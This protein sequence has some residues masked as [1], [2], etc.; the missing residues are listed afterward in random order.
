MAGWDR[1]M[2]PAPGA[3]GQNG[4]R[5]QAKRAIAD[6]VTARP[7]AVTAIPDASGTQAS[8]PPTHR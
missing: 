2:I 3:K 4:G 1:A 5:D 8:A 6:R 7:A